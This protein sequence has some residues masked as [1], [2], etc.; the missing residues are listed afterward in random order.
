[1]DETS[2]GIL[3][4]GC[5][6]LWM[7]KEEVYG[8]NTLGLPNGKVMIAEGYPT[9]KNTLE[10]RGIETIEIDMGQIR[11]ADGSLTCLSVFL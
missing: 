8:C 5:E 10:E 3:P 6:I 11:E 2:F 4:D 9:V 7:P 1:L